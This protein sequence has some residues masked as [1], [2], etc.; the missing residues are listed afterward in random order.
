[1]PRLRPLQGHRSG[2]APVAPAEARRQAVPRV[3][4]VTTARALQRPPSER[5]AREERRTT[6][7]RCHEL[8]LL[9][10]LSLDPPW[11]AKEKLKRMCE[12]TNRHEGHGCRT[13]AIVPGPQRPLSTVARWLG[14][15]A[16][17]LGRFSGL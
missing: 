11:R 7:A 6:T 12:A 14:K 8:R 15:E 9:N 4:A 1:M 2:K 3:P 10:P 5:M 17:R 16:A 13:V